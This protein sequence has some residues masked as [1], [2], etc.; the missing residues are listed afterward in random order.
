MK[1]VLVLV[2]LLLRVLLPVQS[3]L[4]LV[5]SFRSKKMFA[6]ASGTFQIQSIHGAARVVA[7]DSAQKRCAST[8]RP[9]SRRSRVAESLAIGTRSGQYRAKQLAA[10]VPSSFVRHPAG[11]IQIRQATTFAT[12]KR[13][14]PDR[15]QNRPRHFQPHE[16]PIRTQ[17][18]P[19]AAAPRSATAAVARANGESGS[20]WFQRWPQYRDATCCS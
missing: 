6:E 3:V 18:Q 19:L 4:E 7:G 20:P 9:W 10:D 17:R 2:P 13:S 11:R 15:P 5:C 16:P 12:N 14:K 8:R 1:L